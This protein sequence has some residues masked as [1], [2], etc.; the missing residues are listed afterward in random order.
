MFTSHSKV[1]FHTFL[2]QFTDVSYCVHSTICL[3]PIKVAFWIILLCGVTVKAGS[4]VRRKR[5]RKRKRRSRVERKRKRIS[6]SR[7]PRTAVAKRGLW[8][9]DKRSP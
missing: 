6:V 3:T 8:E 5:K 2:E 4:H 9:R 1:T 7:Y